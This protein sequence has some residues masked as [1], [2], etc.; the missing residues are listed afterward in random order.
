M[1]GPYRGERGVLEVLGRAWFLDGGRVGP[2]RRAVW[3]HGA[4]QGLFF[5]ERAAR[6]VDAASAVV[7]AL[8]SFRGLFY[9]ERFARMRG[10]WGRPVEWRHPVTG[11]VRRT[12]VEELM[13][14]AVERGR[15]YVRMLEEEGPEGWPPGPCLETGLPV[16]DGRPMQYFDV[17]KEPLCSIWR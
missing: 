10:V 17:E 1:V 6:W 14:E 15:G 13:E 16:D 4:L 11:E 7:P 8:R 5:S 3:G 12:R 9:R 2:V